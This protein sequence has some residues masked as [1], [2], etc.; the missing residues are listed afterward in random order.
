MALTH[1][2]IFLHSLHLEQSENHHLWDG[3]WNAP[4]IDLSAKSTLTVKVWS[5]LASA[6]LYSKYSSNSTTTFAQ[7]V[8]S[9]FTAWYSFKDFEPGTLIAHLLHFALDCLSFNL[10]DVVRC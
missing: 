7:Q 2:V 3:S 4:E 6:H 10:I 9:N 1:L 8:D 5:E